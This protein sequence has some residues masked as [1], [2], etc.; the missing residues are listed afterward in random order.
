MVL[1]L[2]KRLAKQLVDTTSALLERVQRLEEEQAHLRA[3]LKGERQLRLFTAESA[4]AAQTVPLVGAAIEAF[5]ESIRSPLPRGRAGGLGRAHT[6]W[7]YF[8][9]TFMPE[10]EKERALREEYERSAVGGRARARSALRAA[11]G[12]F[13]RSSGD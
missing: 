1:V 6:A 8:D 2:R 12:T 9:G 7:R 4:A 13:L 10:S 3:W 11:D 5:A